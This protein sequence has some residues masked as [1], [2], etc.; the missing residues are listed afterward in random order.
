MGLRWVS[1]RGQIMGEGAGRG[2][3]TPRM[4]DNSITDGGGAVVGYEFVFWEV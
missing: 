3:G 1:R 4:E 2:H